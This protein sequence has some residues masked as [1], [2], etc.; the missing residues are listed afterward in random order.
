[1]RGRYVIAGWLG[2]LAACSSPTGEEME[3]QR[4]RALWDSRQIGDYQ[5][6]VWLGGAW[7]SGTAIIRVR[8]GVPVSVQSIGEGPALPPEVFSGHDTVE[9]LFAILQRAVDEDADHIGARFHAR[10]GVPLEV[11]IDMRT[12]WAD[13]EQGFGV[14]SFQ[15]Q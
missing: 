5:M 15:L 2:L 4:A 10:Y 1:M 6:T 8:D 9:E 12:T 3:V 14:E 13:D 7:L 11:Y